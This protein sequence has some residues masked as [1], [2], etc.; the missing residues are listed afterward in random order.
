MLFMRR[1]RL[2]RAFNVT[3][4]EEEFRATFPINYWRMQS[5]DCVKTR[6]ISVFAVVFRSQS[7][8]R[9]IWRQGCGPKRRF[10]TNTRLGASRDGNWWQVW[11][12]KNLI[13][14][15]GSGFESFNGMTVD[16]LA[17]KVFRASNWI[18]RQLIWPRSSPRSISALRDSSWARGVKFS[19]WTARGVK[20]PRFRSWV[21]N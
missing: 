9:G 14:V 7:E 13:F 20:F 5:L 19:L 6:S 2:Q 11:G 8:F 1:F 12:R 16:W 18:I 10:E 4:F 3:T 21:N 15:F 17:L